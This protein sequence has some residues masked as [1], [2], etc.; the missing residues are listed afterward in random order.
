MTVVENFSVPD[1]WVREVAPIAIA[2]NAVQSDEGNVPKVP[3]ERKP[4]Y[5]LECH[6]TCVY[7]VYSD[8]TEP[9]RVRVTDHAAACRMAADLGCPFSCAEDASA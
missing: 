5:R 9:Q 6:G 1:P 3:E 4:P 8:G 2:A 7:R